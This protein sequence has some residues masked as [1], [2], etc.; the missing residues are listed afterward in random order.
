MRRT[1][2]QWGPFRLVTDSLRRFQADDA[3]THAAALAYQLFLSTLALSIGGLAVLGMVANV[4]TI[5]VP[6]GAEEQ[7]ANLAEGGALL[8]LAALVGLLW[9]S[10]TFGRRASHAFGTVFRTGPVSMVRGR[11]QGLIVALGIIVLVGAL[12]LVTGV[13]ASLRSLG[14]LEEPI[15]VLGFATTV[16]VEFALFLAAYVTL[17]P[18]GG[19]P[20]RAHVPGAVLMT[21]GWEVFKLVGGLLLAQMFARST[22][23]YGTIG[24]V[25]TVLVL[26]RVATWL[27]LFGAELSAELHERGTRDP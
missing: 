16:A 24:V 17:T 11:L 13:L 15:R 26:M 6:E 9:T 12:P 18:E 25:V 3:D 4:V 1:L 10:S 19:P 23:L 20:W 7:W 5:D 22:L 21:V 2:A 14:V 27:F 8:G